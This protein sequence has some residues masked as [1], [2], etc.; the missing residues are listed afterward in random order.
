MVETTTDSATLLNMWPKSNPATKILKAANRMK[1]HQPIRET[2]T[3]TETFHV[4]IINTEKLLINRA[5]AAV[6]YQ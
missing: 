5:C 4:T 6:F 1:G 3:F 2:A